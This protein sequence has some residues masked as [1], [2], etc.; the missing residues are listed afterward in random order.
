MYVVVLRGDKDMV[1]Y[2]SMVS[3]GEAQAN[4]LITILGRRP[5]CLRCKWHGHMRKD[6]KTPQCRLCK[7]FGH[8]SEDCVPPKPVP[9][10]YSSVVKGPE[11]DI[12]ANEDPAENDSP[13]RVTTEADGSGKAVV[14]YK[15][16]PPPQ[17]SGCQGGY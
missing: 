2:L 8:N 7:E 15:P 1:P 5:V 13:G 6:C 4:I 3:Y 9:R 11:P 14:T 12:S 16:Q 17:L 10:A